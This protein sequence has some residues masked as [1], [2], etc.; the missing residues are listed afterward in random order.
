MYVPILLIVPATFR[1]PADAVQRARCH[2]R[3][4]LLLLLRGM[5]WTSP[6][7]PL[8][9]HLDVRDGIMIVL[10]TQHPGSKQLFNA[11]LQIR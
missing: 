7:L 5:E 9:R 10:R 2:F 4:L 6:C 3:L 11:Y 1:K 8:Q